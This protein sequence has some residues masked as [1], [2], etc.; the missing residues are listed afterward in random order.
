MK[1]SFS[2]VVPLFN[3]AAFVGR[4]IESILCQT[5]QDFEILIVDDCSIDNGVEIVEQYI[6]KDPRIRLLRHDRNM[7]VSVARNHGIQEAN[8]DLI[9]FLDADDEWL[10]NYLETIC[11]LIDIYPEVGVYTTSYLIKYEGEHNNKVIDQSKRGFPKGWVGIIDIFNAYISIGGYPFHTNTIVIKKNILMKMGGF[12]VG[13]VRG[14]DVYTWVR[15]GANYPI[16]YINIPYAIYYKGIPNQTTAFEA[17]SFK[18][19]PKLTTDIEEKSGLYAWE[20]VR[21]LYDL[22]EI[23]EISKDS[24]LKYSSKTFIVAIRIF[25]L[26]NKDG[27]KARR[28]LRTYKIDDKFQFIWLYFWSYAPHVFEGFVKIKKEV[29]KLLDIYLR[30]NGKYGKM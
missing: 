10:P 25:I 9:A 21:Q 30:K 11:G 1:K 14:Q 23:S 18:G 17:I 6:K 8:F 22:G 19:T 24:F 20:K 26:V 29:K 16:C 3:R 15:I 2:V 5:V 12:P 7:G 4:A 28:Y 27:K 13:M